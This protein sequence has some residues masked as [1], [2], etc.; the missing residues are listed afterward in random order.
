MSQ[1]WLAAK[2]AKFQELKDK[3]EE[4]IQQNLQSVK[5]EELEL[6]ASS[7]RQARLKQRKAKAEEYFAREIAREDGIDLERQQNLTYTIE[8]NEQ[9]TRIQQERAAKKD[10]GFADLHTLTMRKCERLADSMDASSITR[11]GKKEGLD[12]LSASVSQEQKVRETRSKRRRFDDTEDVTYINER[13][14]KF[15][16]KVNRAYDKYTEELKESLERGTAV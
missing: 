7:R 10:P 15:N 12:A 8:E 11:R 4:A 5:Q 3:R 14:Q 2:L 16:K 13:N 6:K 9:W 1:D